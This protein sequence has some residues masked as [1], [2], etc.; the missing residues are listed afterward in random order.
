ME[1]KKPS[2]NAKISLMRNRYL[3]RPKQF[4]ADYLHRHCAVEKSGKH[5][6]NQVI[7]GSMTNISTNQHPM[8]SEMMH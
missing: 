7:K 1:C 4:L 5:H 6:C 3:H 8:T 2:L